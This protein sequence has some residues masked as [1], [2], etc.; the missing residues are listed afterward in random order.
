MLWR[1]KNCIED[2]QEPEAAAD[3]VPIWDDWRP[4]VHYSPQLIQNL[5]AE[6]GIER[7]MPG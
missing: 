2:G 3:A 6:L 7:L 1:K 5:E 4:L